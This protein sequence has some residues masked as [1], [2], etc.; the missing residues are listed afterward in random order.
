VARHRKHRRHYG[1]HR[2]H[3]RRFGALNLDLKQSVKLSSPLFG[4]ALGFGVGAGLKAL[5]NQTPQLQQGLPSIVTNNMMLIGPAIGGGLAYLF[6]KKKDH[7]AAVGNLAGALALGV[8]VTAWEALQENAPT[9]FSGVVELSLANGAKVK[10]LKGLLAKSPQ[11]P[12]PPQA[13]RYNG[14]RGLI[15]KS[16]MPYKGIMYPSSPASRG[17]QDVS[18]LSG[19]EEDPMDDFAP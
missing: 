13:G 14:L 2:R 7:A 12:F 17:A 9:M 4:A 3:H 18:V 8:G 19:G 16:A 15:A 11:V 6:R 1:K 10:A 5:I